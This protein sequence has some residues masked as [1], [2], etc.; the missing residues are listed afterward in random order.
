MIL[1]M[2]LPIEIDGKKHLGVENYVMSS[3][4]GEDT[5]RNILSSY[6]S[7]RIKT[8]FNQQDHEQ[9]LEIVYDACNQFNEKKCRS[10][11]YNNKSGNKTIGSIVRD[12]IKSHQD[13]VFKTTDIGTPFR[14]VLD[15]DDVGDVLYGYNLLGHSLL[16]MKHI[17]E[18]LPDLRD[19]PME[20]IFWNSLQQ[21][22]DENAK[23]YKVIPIKKT[24]TK[25]KTH[26]TAAAPAN[27]DAPAAYYYSEDDDVDNDEEEGYDPEEIV[28]PIHTDNGVR[29]IP[30]NPNSR[31]DDLRE[32]GSR[33]DMLYATD[34]NPTDPFQLGPQGDI[35]SR[36]NPFNVFSIYKATEHLVKLMQNG[37]DIKVFLHKPVNSIL[38]EC[39]ITIDPNH[40]HYHI[41][42]WHKFMSKTI[43]Y[44]SFIE[45]EVLCPQ[46]LA[47]F[48]RKRYAT[49]LNTRIGEKIRE[50]LFAS[51]TYQVMEKSYP[52]VAP[53]LRPIILRRE[54]NK[55]SPQEYMD[56]T[57]KL[58][59]LFFNGKFKMDEEGTKRVMLYESFRLSN[60][61]IEEALRF[62][63]IK[64][65]ITPALNVNN[66][67][68]D[69]M[70]A[71]IR[72]RL[73]DK[74]FDDM[75]QYIYY[76][77]YQFYGGMS[78][79]DAYRLLLNDSNKKLLKG[80]D[81]DL[82]T[83][84]RS[85]L[86]DRM[87]RLRKSAIR[88][89]YD[90]YSQVREVVVF[91][92]SI[93]KKMNDEWDTIV[94]DPLD[95]ELMQFVIGQ[96]GKTDQDKAVRLY[97]FLQDI[98]RSLGIVKS[99]IGKRLNEKLLGMF[100]KCFYPKLGN[101]RLD[102][103]VPL[104]KKA[105]STFVRLM[106]LTKTLSINDTNDVN[107]LWRII[108]P[109]LFL[110]QQDAFH[111]HHLFQE[112]KTI[113]TSVSQQDMVNTLIR[114]LNCLYKKGQDIPNDH[115]Y[116]LVQLI[117]GNDDIPLWTDP[118]FEILHEE[119][120]GKHKKKRLV[121]Y[122]LIHPSFEPF[123][124]TLQHALHSNEAVISRATYALDALEKSVIHP[125]RIIFFSE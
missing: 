27:V 121:R 77:L 16:R 73:D 118:S 3:L 93:K 97:A 66:T 15:V 12:V 86:D 75:Y 89:K 59:H 24:K 44:Y 57:D 111:P 49:D 98:I 80:T 112:I 69:P 10:V 25:T 106:E 34:A 33:A 6:P 125:R 28:V 91:A 52:H 90:Q 124:I 37:F 55:F 29:W 114:I 23:T 96:I 42:Y 20:Y 32:L 105:P 17:V 110:F 103:S 74:D 102:K 56:I 108:Y 123:Y 120:N 81:P 30:T 88:A 41:D 92:N 107:S 67:V 26:A 5:R 109:I 95:L 53:E 68:L 60:E 22:I 104:P 13:F 8:E 100:V 14:S 48:I 70:A 9:Y 47:G 119:E 101:I 79:N 122:N 113:H 117:S 84:L 63:P 2:N 71:D 94:P 58:Y 72:V 50:V 36:T 19:G 64:V 18:K 7:H 35:V 99:I 65:L 4:I 45:K 31:L 46:N 82:S 116:L 78:K 39:G 38:A 51:F 21:K 83:R 61:Q 40:R 43:P 76:R 115:F 54:M 62:T 87:T 1:D 85:C 11:Q